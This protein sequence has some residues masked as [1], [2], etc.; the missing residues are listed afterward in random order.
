MNSISTSAPAA[1]LRSHGFGVALFL[2]DGGAHFDDIAG[3]RARIA[4]AAEHVADRGL[5]PCRKLAGDPETT[6]A[7]VSAMCSQVH[8]SRS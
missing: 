3:D 6:R 5:D 8:A 2:G 7:R 4:L 1:Y